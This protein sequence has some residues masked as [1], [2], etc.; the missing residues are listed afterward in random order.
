V[1]RILTEA[2]SQPNVPALAAAVVDLLDLFVHFK[3]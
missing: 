3:V 1:S 2:V